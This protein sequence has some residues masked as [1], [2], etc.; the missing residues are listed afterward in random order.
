MSYRIVWSDFAKDDYAQILLFL[1]DKYSVNTAL[2]FLD[3][4]EKIVEQI[5]VFPLS[6]PVLEKNPRLHRAV[7]NKNTSLLYRINQYEIELLF[8]QDNRMNDVDL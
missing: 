6:F 1:Q 8:F 2:A 7:I 4:T 3:K 5:T